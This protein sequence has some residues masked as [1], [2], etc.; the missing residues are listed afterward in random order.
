MEPVAEFQS[1]SWHTI[2]GRGRVA[3]CRWP[4]DGPAMKDVLG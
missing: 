4:E 1:L 3:A 2:K